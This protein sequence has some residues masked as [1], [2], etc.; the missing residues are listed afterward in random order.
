MN[1]FITYITDL[2]RYPSTAQGLA[3]LGGL[4]GYTI[5]PENA[6]EIAAAVATIV[7]FIAT[8]FS[9]SDVKPK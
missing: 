6:A 5:T 1:K 3:I 4:V 2:L 9:D 7:G 8:F